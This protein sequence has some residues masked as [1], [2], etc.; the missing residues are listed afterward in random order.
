MHNTAIMVFSN[1]WISCLIAV[2]V[3]VCA[4][5]NHY[6]VI[7]PG[8]ETCDDC[9]LTLS[10]VIDNPQ[11]YLTSGTR[12]TFLSGTHILDK[13][14]PV[15][16]NGVSNLTIE[17]EGMIEDGFHWTIRQSNVIIKCQNTTGGFIFNRSS[18]A[19]RGLTVVNCGNSFLNEFLEERLQPFTNGLYSESFSVSVYAQIG[20][21]L[22]FIDC[23]SVNMSSLSVQNCSGNCVMFFNPRQVTMNQVYIAHNSPKHYQSSS[24]CGATPITKP[25][26]VGSNVFFYYL[27]TPR[28]SY[29]SSNF[30][31]F[32]LTIHDSIFS[33]GGGSGS[34]GTTLAG[35]TIFNLMIAMLNVRIDSVL[36]YDNAGGNFGAIS[37]YS[38]FY[39]RNM[40]S[41]FANRYLIDI[42][43]TGTLD[44]SFKF[45]ITNGV[46]CS[47]LKQADQTSYTSANVFI[48]NSLFEG[49]A[50]VNSAGINI[51][52]T[53]VVDFSNI[54][55][56]LYFT[57][58]RSIIRGNHAP[59]ASCIG[60]G[61][62]VSF[63]AQLRVNL[64]DVLM[65][66]NYFLEPQNATYIGI[67]ASC[68]VF[69]LTSIA[70]MDNVTIIDQQLV[71]I[72]G[73]S[74]NLIFSGNSLF[75]NNTGSNEGGAIA[76]ES[77]C[78]FTLAENASI[79]FMD[80]R[81]QLGAAIY[82]YRPH[83]IA[84]IK[85]LCIFQIAGDSNNSHMYFYGNKASITGDVI[86]GG[87]LGSCSL[88]TQK[89]VIPIVNELTNI[90][91]IK[92]DNSNMYYTMSSYPEKLCLCSD[93]Q[94]Q[95][96]QTMFTT[97]PVFPG[98]IVDISVATIGQLNGFTTGSILINAN[99]LNYTEN[100]IDSIEKPVCTNVSLYVKIESS[101]NFTS[102]FPS[103]NFSISFNVGLNPARILEL[104][105][106]VVVTV[107]VSDCPPGFAVNSSFICQCVKLLENDI[108]CN[109]ISG[110]ISHS[111]NVWVGYDTDSN[112]TVLAKPCPF[113]FCNHNR[114]T[115]TMLEPHLQCAYHR[116]GRLC[117]ECA[118]GYSLLLGSNECGHCP[119]NNFLSLLIVFSIA[120]ILLVVLLI[121][122]NLTVSVGT[123]NGLIFYANIVK[124]NETI[125]FPNGP[126]IILSN[127]ISFV[128]LDLGIQTCFYKG[129][130]SYAKVWLQF[131]FPIYLWVII[132]AIIIISKYSSKLS[133][134]VGSNAAPVLATLMLLSF[135]KLVRTLVLSLRISYLHYEDGT[136]KF[137]W[138]VNG[139]LSYVSSKHIFLFLAAVFIYLFV[140]LP[141]TVFVMI[142]PVRHY[143]L[144]V[145]YPCQKASN[146]LSK[147]FPSLNLKLKPFLDAFSGPLNNSTGYWVGLELAARLIITNSVPF[148]GKTTILR[149]VFFTVL[150]ILSLFAVLG[151]TYKRKL[152]NILEVWS[153]FN[154]LVI[155]V[156][157]LG[158]SVETGSIISVSFMLATF[159]AIVVCHIFWQFK[160]YIPEFQTCG[161]LIN[162]EQIK[163]KEQNYDKALTESS[164]SDTRY[165]E[166][167]LEYA[168]TSI[169]I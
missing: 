71:G 83:T 33:F 112:R 31:Q 75:Q 122:L 78:K 128:N 142:G 105:I 162:S 144:A 11:L 9:K 120:G 94:S 143:C 86:Y 30:Q 38:D 7:A 100:T 117:G 167:L 65:T 82:I 10:D 67:P 70:N 163:K 129:M 23:E 24:C 8:G 164:T 64:K 13:D 19:L 145:C 5:G 35:M 32:N 91:V 49:N 134:I 138:S 36:F 77:D 14:A 152:N 149:V 166:P 89:R 92:D 88:F 118:D 104:P 165:R 43:S 133:K 69:V 66:D 84:L 110:K 159:V 58:E 25:S 42:C 27:N 87:N 147:V 126:V 124:I 34:T 52:T 103:D 68:I 107:P 20:S 131:V 98:Q 150:F 46:I 116:S 39:I 154:L 57:V 80:N 140:L 139:D 157:A 18:I 41:S 54:L 12:L 125:F 153:L 74:S 50:A 76:L 56:Q 135:T 93:N 97:N 90:F 115:F 141:F 26:C 113:D 3:I 158:G 168:H 101:E 102:P 61:G 53:F 160:K 72:F 161:F 2:S 96:N 79:V 51:D 156:F 151:G 28:C 123:I 108:T 59:L 121:A 169:N 81:A 95:C 106:P 17:G 109:I 155:I 62:F 99:Y 127:F 63:P 73:V 47:P 44:I 119:N 21:S 55:A 48:D 132:I 137:V 45:S 60:S 148:N 6:F 114:V 22:A 85:Q 1:G 16:I 111:T 136:T 4:Y 37:S 146:K 29:N 130:T 15:L 40:T